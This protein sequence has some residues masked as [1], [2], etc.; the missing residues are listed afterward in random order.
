MM[1]KKVEDR[2]QGFEQLIE[3]GTLPLLACFLELVQ[4]LYKRIFLVLALGFILAFTFSVAF[5]FS[6]TLD[7]VLGRCI[8]LASNGSILFLNNTNSSKEIRMLEKKKNVW[9]F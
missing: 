5:A 8:Y 7:S 6:H 1:T 2:Y 9:L 3:A 4:F